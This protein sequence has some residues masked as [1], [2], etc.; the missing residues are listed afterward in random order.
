MSQYELDGHDLADL[1]DLSRE[2]FAFTDN[3][4]GHVPS[5]GSIIY[6]VWDPAEHFIYVGSGAPPQPGGLV[7]AIVMQGCQ[8]QGGLEPSLLAESGTSRSPRACR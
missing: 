4:S 5:Y 8:T 6:T 1:F 2:P 7:F 3:C